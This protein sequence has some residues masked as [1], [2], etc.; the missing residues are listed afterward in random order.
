[1]SAAHESTES[2]E[3]IRYSREDLSA[4]RALLLHE[5]GS[6]RGV[7]SMAQQAAEKAIKAAMISERTEVPRS[8]DLRSLRGLVRRT[9]AASI[10]DETLEWLT[11]IGAGS[12]YPDL[13]RVPSDADAQRAF[14]VAEIVVADVVT[15]FGG[16]TR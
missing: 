8:H 6:A 2:S 11:W 16:L 4:A 14:A 10:D 9:L 12:R 3:W 15:S 13:D 5:E 7:V 1:M